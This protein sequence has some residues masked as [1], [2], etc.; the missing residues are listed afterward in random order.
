MIWMITI[1]KAISKIQ[2]ILTSFTPKK[3]KVRLNNTLQNTYKKDRIKCCFWNNKPNSWAKDE[4]VVKPPKNPV[5]KKYFALSDI[6]QCSFINSVITP[7]RKRPNTF[8]KNIA[9][10]IPQKVKRHNL[11]NNK[12]PIAPIA[13]PIPVTK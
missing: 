9:I 12:R 8:T 1:P 3:K 2:N 7:I 10:G 4:K 13:P 11:I 5:I 6:D